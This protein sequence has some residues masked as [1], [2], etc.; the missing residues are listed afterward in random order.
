[1]QKCALGQE[2][3]SATGGHAGGGTGDFKMSLIGLSVNEMS[4][5]KKRHA[6]DG[7]NRSD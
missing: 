2:A 4:H 3:V 1:M 6:R 7:K 5:R